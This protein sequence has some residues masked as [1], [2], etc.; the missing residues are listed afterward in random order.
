MTFL[1][2]LA[3]TFLSTALSVW[4]KISGAATTLV[5]EIP[6]DEEQIVHDAFVAAQDVLTKGGSTADALNA[7]WL[8]AKAGEKAELS[9]LGS[10]MLNFL[11]TG[12][13]AKAGAPD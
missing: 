13:A 9:K 5:N 12:T 3:A 1:E 4:S 10:V 2:Q 7:A 11:V 8:S 6:A